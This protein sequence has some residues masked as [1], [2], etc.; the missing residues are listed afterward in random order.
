[1][2]LVDAHVLQILQ[3]SERDPRASEAC[4]HATLCMRI[5]LSPV[6]RLVVVRVWVGEGLCNVL[7]SGRG[8]PSNAVV[9]VNSFLDVKLVCYFAF[10]GR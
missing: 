4:G 10:L 9:Q 1:M 8:V 2:R 6:G 3:L 5:V 7:E